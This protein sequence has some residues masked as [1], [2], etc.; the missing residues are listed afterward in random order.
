MAQFIFHYAHSMTGI[1]KLGIW[2]VP[3]SDTSALCST[4]HFLNHKPE[5]PRN[6]SKKSLFKA[7]ISVTSLENLIGVC[8]YLTLPWGAEYLNRSFPL[9]CQK[10]L[11]GSHQINFYLL[12][13]NVSCPSKMI[14]PKFHYLCLFCNLVNHISVISTLK[15]RKEKKKSAQEGWGKGSDQYRCPQWFRPSILI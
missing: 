3:W 13:L 12:L 8:C 7:L 10:S 9:C 5:A 4:V 2:K 6:I 14:R 1:F 11:S 15:K